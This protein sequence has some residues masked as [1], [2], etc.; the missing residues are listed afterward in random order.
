[1]YYALANITN[2][3]DWF[4]W[5]NTLSGGFF[6]VGILGAFWVIIF[7]SLKSYETEKSF[8]TASF[9]TNVLCFLL[10]LAFR[11]EIVTI[12]HLFLTSILTLMSLFLVKKAEGGL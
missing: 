1:M 3:M 4:V 10:W 12:P 11:G 7:I 9:L 8:A 5:I 6:G 2:P